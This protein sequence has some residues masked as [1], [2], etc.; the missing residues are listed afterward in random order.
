ML[1]DLVSTITVC[2]LT[3]RVHADGHDAQSLCA[4]I[5]TEQKRFLGDPLKINVPIRIGS[6]DKD[7]WKI[8]IL[9]SRWSSSPDPQVESKLH[10][11]VIVEKKSG[12]EFLPGS[13]V[14]TYIQIGN[15]SPNENTCYFDNYVGTQMIS[16]LSPTQCLDTTNQQRPVQSPL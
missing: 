7:D 9:L 8:G 14:Q 11:K 1:L 6:E 15:N 12:E 10:L 3:W 5:P 4:L 13:M 16:T 2:L